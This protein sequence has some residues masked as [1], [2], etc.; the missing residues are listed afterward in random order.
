MAGIW[1]AVTD[2]TSLRLVVPSLVRGGG[3]WTMDVLQVSPDRVR[4]V[5]CVLDCHVP[6]RRSWGSDGIRFVFALARQHGRWRYSR[7]GLHA[8]IERE[9]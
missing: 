3:G 1:C 8:T 5:Q 4:G 2:A 9:V 7:N 6:T